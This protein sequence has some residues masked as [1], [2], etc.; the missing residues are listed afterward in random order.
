MRKLVIIIFLIII[1][2]IF[3]Q[4]QSDCNLAC[5][6]EGYSH[7]ICSVECDSEITIP[8]AS[9]CPKI[10]QAILVIGTEA[11]DK[12]EDGESHISGD[13][14]RKWIWVL[15][16]LKTK[17][18]TIVR[19]ASD[20]TQHSGPIIGIK[21]NFLADTLASDPV[22]AVKTGGKICLP[23]DYVCVEF[24]S[25]TSN[26]YATYEIS[27][28]SVDLSTFN[29]SWSNKAAMYL[30]SLDDAEGFTLQTSDY[31]S[32]VVGDIDTD[33]IWL[34]NNG[35]N[36]AG[37]FYEDSSN[38]KKLAGYVAMDSGSKDVNVADVN[39]KSTSGSNVQIDLRGD[40]GTANSLDLVLDILGEEGDASVNG[41]DDLTINLKHDANGEF[42][43]LGNTSSTADDG[44]ITWSS[45]ELGKKT[46]DL[47]TLYGIIIKSPKSN[48][49]SD[50]VQL[51]IPDDQVF[52]NVKLIGKSTLAP[53]TRIENETTVLGE[54]AP[55]PIL[56][57]ELIGKENYNVVFVGGPCANPLIEEYEEFPKC[58]SWNLEFG[59]ALIKIA[60]NGK[61]TA[62]LVAG[63]TADDTRMASRFIKD[64]FTQLD[65]EGKEIILDSNGIKRMVGETFDIDF[66][67]YPYPFLQNGKFGN[68]LFVFGDK[69]KSD[70]TVGASDI[71]SG[72]MS[73]TRNIVV[74]QNV[75][76]DYLSTG[77]VTDKIPLGN[78]IGDSNYYTKLLSFGDIPTLR[79]EKVRIGGNDFNTKD[80][81][82]LYNSGTVIQTALSSSDFS[83]EDD[84]V[85]ELLSGNLRYY[86]VFEEEVDLSTISASNPLEIKFLNKEYAITEV[87]TNK[88]TTQSATEYVVNIGDVVEIDSDEVELIDIG[89]GGEV[90]VRV[91]AS[92]NETRE[93]LP[94]G[95][96]INFE[97]I[98][99]KN[100][101]TY[102]TGSDTS[103]CC[104][105]ILGF[106]K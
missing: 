101:E 28:S 47:R 27:K 63:T 26:T 85:M 87:D 36:V 50:K 22:K 75:T 33:K 77:E 91:N 29:T 19:D 82:L 78:N 44:D 4:A 68:T 104:E 67:D 46:S 98:D 12:F 64:N 30:N 45:L 2:V 23:E 90:I 65:L 48:A 17:G 103:C 88:I 41:N 99:I 95:R 83:Y 97:G 72:L 84:V 39:Y 51:E 93:I 57:S 62:L 6:K 58:D 100:I 66:S 81:V 79:R 25:L 43:G 80:A 9:D 16:N 76:K 8:G 37:V 42:D 73:I 11:L 102:K 49:D 71:I 10:G 5:I 40:L 53:T 13:E 18:S 32:S 86:Y 54:I 21:N 34:I 20:D 24:T 94:L 56:A 38:A 55:N 60:K 74:E 15:K 105:D 89:K 1:L 70:D 106:L 59:E 14:D 35:S 31:D 7:G 69:A 96:R 52:A 92:G 3:S 61:N